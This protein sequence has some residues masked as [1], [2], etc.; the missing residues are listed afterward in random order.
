MLLLDAGDALWS[1]RPFT[2][3]SAHRLPIDVMNS[4]AYD[5][6][7]LGARDL[8]L[9]ADLLRQRMAEATF[10]ILSANVVEAAT[11]QPF[12][13]PSAILD[14]AGH[15]VAIVGLTDAPA[16]TTLAPG[17]QVSDPLAA[18]RQ[19][20]GEAAAQA[21]IVV[22]LSHAGPAVDAQLAAELPQID[23]VV[24][25]GYGGAGDR[26]IVRA[27]QAPILLAERPSTGHA[28]RY[29]G[30]A[31]LRVD[32]QGQL[33]DLQWQ[34]VLLDPTWADDPQMQALLARYTAGQ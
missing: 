1:D 31:Q 13:R 17:F 27:G 26:P 19:A 14:L 23:L 21:D 3:Q 4:L 10:P 20:V 6:A 9:G 15:R 22:L 28:G 25:G 18:A 2:V 11:G 8:Q 24:A 16:A 29:V 7:A 5:A 32:S 33:Q 12:A 30:Q 34:P